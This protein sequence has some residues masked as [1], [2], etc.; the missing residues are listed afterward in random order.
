VNWGAKNIVAVKADQTENIVT[1]PKD[2][3]K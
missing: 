3:H 1:A 2:I